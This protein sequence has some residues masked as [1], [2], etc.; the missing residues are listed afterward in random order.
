MSASCGKNIRSL[1]LRNIGCTAQGVSVLGQEAASALTALEVLDLGDN[2]IGNMGAASVS[3]CLKVV[4]GTLKYLSLQACPLTA[5]ETDFSGVEAL[6]TMLEQNMNLT[7]LDLW[8]TQLGVTGGAA[9]A[10]SVQQPYTPTEVLAEG[11]T[12]SRVW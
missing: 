3:E 2:A 6:A 12:Y 8:Q 10:K 11:G 4:A 1:Q 7:S 5:G 9:V